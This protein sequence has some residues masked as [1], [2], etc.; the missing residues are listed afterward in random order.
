M[1]DGIYY[2]HP[3]TD[4]HKSTG[5]WYD[6]APLATHIQRDQAHIAH[7]QVHFRYA[8]LLPFIPDAMRVHA[9]DLR[10]WLLLLALESHDG[11]SHKC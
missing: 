1:L 9:S 7:R 6:N 4:L 2:N 11:S 3:W 10:D 5:P 8:S